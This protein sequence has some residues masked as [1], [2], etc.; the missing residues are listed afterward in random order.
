MEGLGIHTIVGLG[1]ALQI[2]GPLLAILV[3][4]W[5]DRR[6]MQKVQSA[7]QKNITAILEQYKADTAALAHQHEIYMAEMRRMYESNVELVKRSNAIAADFKEVLI[8]NVQ[9]STELTLAI[10]GN[11]FCPLQRLEFSPK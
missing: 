2:G 1:T 3:I 4:W 9:T 8:L 6:D 10:K 11:L 5:F 7:N